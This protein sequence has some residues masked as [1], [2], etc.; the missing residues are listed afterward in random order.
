M[1]D[2]HK[3]TKYGEEGVVCLLSESTNAKIVIIIVK[4]CFFILFIPW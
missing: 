3:M 1:S 2:Y 4:Y